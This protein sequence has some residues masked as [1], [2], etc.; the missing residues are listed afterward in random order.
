M[1]TSSRESTARIFNVPILEAFTPRGVVKLGFDVMQRSAEIGR[2]FFPWPEGKRA[3]REFQNKLEAFDLFAHVDSVLV[4]PCQSE[5]RL[6]ELIRKTEA[7]EPYRA[8]WA[9]E[10]LGYY[11]ATKLLKQGETPRNL[12]NTDDGEIPEK[13]LVPLHSGMGLGIASRLLPTINSRSSVC[14]IGRMLDRFIMLC[15]DNSRPGYAAAAYE[16][17]GLVTRNLHPQML[18]RLDDQLEKKD[19]NLRDYFWHGV[20][21]GIY[22]TATNFLPDGNTGRAL[23]MIYEEPPYESGRR[24]ALAGLAWAMTLVNIRHPEI[25]ANFLNHLESRFASHDAFIN[26]VSSSIM[27]WRD[28]TVDDPALKAFCSYQPCVSDKRL[29]EQWERMIRGPCSRSLEHCYPALKAQ[30]RLGEIFRCDYELAV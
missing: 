19:E 24:N 10:G 7:L 29:V 28:S 9:T 17:L 15:R 16:S 22:F 18:R 23:G 11:M 2:L 4:I 26:G 27:I 6:S 21:R 30:R 3:L 12:L 25:L 14:E 5:V 1:S 13:S 20:G 8:V